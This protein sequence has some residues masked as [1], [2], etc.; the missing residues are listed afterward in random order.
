MDLLSAIAAG[1][2]QALT[3]MLADDVVF[4]SPA[5][6]YHERDQVLD[7]LALG[8][9]AIGAATPTREPIEIGVGETLTFIRSGVGDEALEGVLIEVMDGEGQIAE[10]TI[11]LRPIGAVDRALRRVARAL[12]DRAE[13]GA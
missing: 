9:V 12:T 6:T 4:H 2:R 13:R 11:L 1:D 7:V 10:I 8:G 3:E 5:T